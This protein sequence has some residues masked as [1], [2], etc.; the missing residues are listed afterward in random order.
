M[1]ACS[2]RILSLLLITI[3]AAAN[4]QAAVPAARAGGGCRGVPVTEEATTSV[5]MTDFCFE[6]SIVRVDVGATVTWR[7]ESDQPHS[8]TGQNA[9]WGSYEEL[10]NGA[11]TSRAFETTGTYAYY[12]MIHPGMIGVVVVGDGTG[13]GAEAS[14]AD[15]GYDDALAVVAEPNQQGELV[16]PTNSA[17]TGDDGRTGWWALAGAGA[18]GV[19]AGGGVVGVLR[20]R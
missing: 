3:A 9:S 16:A 11:A 13:G 10:L 15:A 8:V 7:N 4:A 20:R 6:P 2:A 1:L 17:S 12:C 14:R 18:V 5:T 19:I